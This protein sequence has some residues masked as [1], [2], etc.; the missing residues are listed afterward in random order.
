MRHTIWK[1]SAALFAGFILFWLAI[2]YLLPLLLPFLLGAGLALAAEPAVSF[3]Q[4]T[5]RLPRGASAGIGVSLCLTILI[6]LMMSLGALLLR[7][8]SAVAGRIPQVRQLLQ[9][10]LEGLQQ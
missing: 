5:L 2:R 3:L 1:K 4:Q 8:L 6:L 10:G 9:Q 7:E